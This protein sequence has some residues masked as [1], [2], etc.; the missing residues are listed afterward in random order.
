MGT[1]FLC[2]T[3]LERLSQTNV[4]VGLALAALGFALSLLA[5]RIAIFVRKEDKV[6]DNDKVFI[7]VKAFS[8]VMILVA[9]I[10]LVMDVL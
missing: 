4:I 10:I 6:S 7:G 3:L 8:I 2:G 9:L 5:R 1:L